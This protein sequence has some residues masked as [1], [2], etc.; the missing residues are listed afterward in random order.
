MDFKTVCMFLPFLGV[1][2]GYSLGVY[3]KSNNKTPKKRL[4]VYITGMII[5]FICIAILIIAFN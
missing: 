2:W 5:T 4:A 3:V 1:A